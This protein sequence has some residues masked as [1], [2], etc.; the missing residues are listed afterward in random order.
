MRLMVFG[1]GAAREVIG[2]NK[3]I[4]AGLSLLGLVPSQED[5]EQP[6]LALC[7]QVHP[8][9]KGHVKTEQEGGSL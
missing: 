5:E 9:R 7:P 3:V 8:L 4:V 2:L 6:F 1:G